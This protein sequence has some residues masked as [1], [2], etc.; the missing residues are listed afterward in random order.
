LGYGYGPGIGENF[1]KL[2]LIISRASG[3]PLIEGAMRFAGDLI[4]GKCLQIA[5]EEFEKAK[6]AGLHELLEEL[7]ASKKPAEETEVKAPP[8]EVVTSQISGIEIMDLE[9]AV[10]LL[11]KNGVY[12][13]S[14]MGCTGPI[15]LVNEA[16]TNEALKILADNDYIAKEQADC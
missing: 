9:D 11:W 16:K 1:N 5:K 4:K 14:G 2:I 8:K 13:E 3:A 15:I 10:K 12:A 6:K 7:K